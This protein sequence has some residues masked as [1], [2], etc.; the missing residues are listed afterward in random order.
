M[1]LAFGFKLYLTGII[2]A[3]ISY[4][5][6]FFALL[7]ISDNMNEGEVIGAG[8]FFFFSWIIIP[9]IYLVGLTIFYVSKRISHFKKNKSQLEVED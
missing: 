8:L 2:A 4:S 3:I 6:D 7:A 5:V 1:K 9:G